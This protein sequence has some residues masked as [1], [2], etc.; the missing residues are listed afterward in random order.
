MSKVDLR[1]R[2]LALPDLAVGTEALCT[3]T[4][5]S[6]STG[7]SEGAERPESRQLADQSADPPDASLA[8]AGVAAQPWGDPCPPFTYLAG[9]AGCGKTFLVKE[10]AAREKGLVL[11][12]STGIASVNLGEGTTINS[13]LGY[14]NTASL[15][16]SYV[17]G[18]LTARL[19]KLWRAGV[20][21]IILDEVSMVSGDQLTYLVKAI[22]EVNGKGYVLGKWDEGDEEAPPALGL[23]LCGDFA[24]LAPINEPWAWESPEWERFAA[25]T[26]TLTEIRRQADPDFINALRLARLGHGHAILPYFADRLSP[27]TDDRFEGPTL[28][29][30]NQQVDRYNYIRMSRLPGTDAYF[31]SSREGKQRSEWG[32]PD[33]PPTTWGV[34]LRLHLKV[35][36]LVMVLANKQDEGLSGRRSYRYVNGDLGEFVEAEGRVAQVRLQRT[37]QVVAVEYVRREVLQPCDAARRKELRVAGHSEAISENGKFE[38]TG[39]IEYCP[40]RVAYATTVW[41]AQGLSL[42]RVQVN[43]RDPFCKTPGLVYVALSRARTAEGLRLV[44]TA[45]ALVERCVADPR[46]AAWL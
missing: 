10:W 17:N 38:I 40:L 30:K 36:A 43:L 41:K 42:D 27:E 20:R 19:G 14:F 29:T 12:A 9:P 34:P 37:G 45:A 35:G 11:T 15:Q 1:V 39:W 26:V 46:L 33:K 13:L 7:D 28:L 44:G 2:D 3:S 32:N 5:Y 22:E 6:T 4:L 23:T 31:E 24:Q 18:F 21:R 16:E 25:H 8:G